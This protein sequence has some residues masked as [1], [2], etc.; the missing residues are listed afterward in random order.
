MKKPI[1]RTKK[2]DIFSVNIDDQFVKYFQYVTNDLLQLNSDVIRVFLEK[3]PKESDLSLGEIA[4]LPVEFYAHTIVSVGV[5]LGVWNKVGHIKDFDPYVPV[6]FRTWLERG[7]IGIDEKKI[8]PRQ[9]RGWYIWRI[10]DSE[11]TRVAQLPEEHKKAE[12]GTVFNPFTI[13]KRIKTGTYGL[14]N[15]PYSP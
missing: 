13:E 2:G 1:V 3:V 14:Q 12:I 7:L 5:K 10:E 15:Y 8:H 6:F 11:L 9:P 4:K